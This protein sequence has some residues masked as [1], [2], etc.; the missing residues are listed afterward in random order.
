MIQ[1]IIAVAGI[2][3]AANT[4]NWLLGELTDQERRRQKRLED[5]LD[6]FQ[7]R[8]NTQSRRHNNNIYEMARA[9]F[10]H[11]KAKYM[12]EVQFFKNEKQEI[13]ANLDMLAQTIEKE[14]SNKAISAHQRDSL[15]KDDI[16]VQDAKNRLDAYWLY[17]DWFEVKLDDLAKFK[18]YPEIYKL[19]MP[20]ALLPE[21]YLYVGKLAYIVKGEIS[22][23]KDP[24]T[25]GW[26][27][28]DQKL[29]LN[30]YHNKKEMEAYENYGNKEEFMIL[31]DHVNKNKF[32]NASMLKGELY[33]HIFNKSSFEATPK[34]NEKPNQTFSKM[35]YNGVYLEL[36]RDDKL[37]PLKNYQRSDSFSVKIKEHD[38][39]L[40][41][42]VVTERV[43]EQD[44]E[45][46]N[47]QVPLVFHKSFHEEVQKLDQA[48]NINQLQVVSLQGNILELKLDNFLISLKFDGDAWS[49]EN[50][51]NAD[52]DKMGASAF[53]MPYRVVFVEEEEYNKNYKNLSIGGYSV[54]REC[55]SWIKEQFT[56]M[57]HS[58]K[59]SNQDFKFFEKWNNIIDTQIKDEQYTELQ[60]NY[61]SCRVEGSI[62]TFHIPNL[63][64]YTKEFVDSYKGEIKE[65]KQDDI[66]I[67]LDGKE[68]GTLDSYDKDILRAKLEYTHNLK[69]SNNSTL[70]IK[71]KNY[72]GVLHRQKNALK[73]FNASKMLNLDLKQMLISPHLISHKPMVDKLKLEFTNK[74]LT[75]N[76]Q[77]IL[78]KAF[79]EKNIFLI[80]GP[81]G[82]GKTTIIKEMVTQTLKQDKHS[83]ILIVSQ[84]NVAV[85]NVLDGIDRENKEWF[86]RDGHSMVRIATDVDKIQYDN[87]KELSLQKWFESYK[88]GVKEKFVELEIDANTSKGIFDNLSSSS[89]NEEI[90]EHKEKLYK[91]AEEWMELTYKEDFKDVDSEIK[92]LLISR[93]QILGATCMGLANK[94][95]GLDLMEFDIAIID[96]AG[97]ATAPELLIPI[98]RAKKVILIGDHNQLPPTIDRKL[99]QKLERD[100][101][102]SLSDSDLDILKKSFFEELFEKVPNSNKAMLNE[103][104]RMPQ[105]VG[106]LISELFYERK[107]KN[108]HIKNSDHFID[109]KNTIQWVDT[110]GKQ[111]YNNN[112]SCFNMVEVQKITTLVGTIDKYLH[113]KGE[114]KTVGIITPYSAQKQKIRDRVKCL[115]LENISNLKIDTVDSFQGEEADIVIYSTVRTSGN[116]S[117]LIDRKRL[118]VAISRTKENLFFVGDMEFFYS[119]TAKEDEENLFVK[120][121][122]SI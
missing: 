57:Q 88:E 22:T 21:N 74:S 41:N 31:I 66:S 2:T 47:A 10:A 46:G 91:L 36:T 62:L 108:G 18:Q 111:K 77:G 24:K 93:H 59:T 82:T 5:E 72:L 3:I 33:Q 84:Q 76:Q 103:Q 104:F 16:K 79:N 87:I 122:D 19:E 89:N 99:L 121:I 52:T 100:D 54:A 38:L 29:S 7:E 101:E 20:Q 70:S 45:L 106:T 86:K 92:K 98:L 81:P 80:Q 49:I 23:G 58:K 1:V 55:L 35:L 94:A 14:L 12:A 109:P 50:I 112:F 71:V 120:I 64:R 63:R 60:V 56:Y 44:G 118:N 15:L 4:L 85:D 95:L 25:M 90:K 37:H 105:K 68:V 110:K 8:F 117:F 97:R 96:E 26:N 116:I 65:K 6:G 13:K 69:A 9:D 102:D 83:K 119:A 75:N 43:D 30:D 27:R 78:T 115:K 51:S 32:F 107:L 61:E 34:Y 17:L 28:Y 113:K 114:R 67:F 40:K 39:L 48:L 42:I 53:T 11:I 73:D